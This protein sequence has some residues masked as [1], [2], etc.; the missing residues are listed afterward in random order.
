[1]IIDDDKADDVIT[2]EG[3]VPFAISRAQ[4]E[5]KFKQWL[6]SLWFA[7]T[8]LKM[9]SHLKQFSG[10]YRPYWTYDAHTISHWSGERGDYYW[11]TETYTVVENGQNVTKTRQVRHTRW[12]FCS[13]VYQDFFDDVLV[14]AGK[15][16]DRSRNYDLNGLKR[17]S[18][19]YLSGFGAERYSI[20]CED[21]W[22]S[23]KTIDDSIYGSV[24]GEIGGDEQRV[25]G[26]NTAYNGIT[27][28][29][30]APVWIN[31]YSI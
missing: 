1:M 18:P 27:Y 16:E 15:T 11:V 20:S 3:V 2:P 24:R 23:A 28:N 13:G 12:S 21:G 10:I 31:S 17:Y 26:I 7:P 19:E 30:S 6:D 22:R 14:R 8:L 4:A 9:E 29:T 25:Q 5:Q